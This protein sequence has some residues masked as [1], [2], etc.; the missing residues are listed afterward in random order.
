MI[1]VQLRHGDAQPPGR[2]PASGFA[3]LPVNRRNGRYP[4][5]ETHAAARV[6]P[7][8]TRPGCKAMHART[9]GD[10]QEFEGSVAIQIG[11][12]NTFKHISANGEF[13]LYHA[14]QGGHD[15]APVARRH[16]DFRIAITVHVGYEGARNVRSLRQVT[17]RERF[18]RSADHGNF[19]LGADGDDFTF[20]GSLHV[21]DG[22]GA[23]GGRTGVTTPSLLSRDS[24][25]RVHPT[26]RIARQDYRYC[27][28]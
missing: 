1:P 27:R 7:A 18:A 19:A 26:R 17:V 21:D 2:A 8:E 13:L 24:V 6:C 3:N 14:G 22:R 4:A 16:D 25:Q 20:S 9:I 12:H 15:D 10:G 5:A 28:I 23:E 11:E